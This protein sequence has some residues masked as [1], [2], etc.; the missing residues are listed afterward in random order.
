MSGSA[1]RL[2]AEMKQSPLKAGV[3]LAGAVVAA[4]VWGPRVA[5][6]FGGGPA[7]PVAGPA[8]VEEDGAGEEVEL[9]RLDPGAIRSEF[10]RVSEDAR[11]LA[12][13]VRPIP[14][15]AGAGDPFARPEVPAPPPP[16]L[17]Q[18]QGQE[19]ESNPAVEEAIRAAA[20]R[21]EGVFQFPRGRSVV[22]D[23]V[24]LRVG[25]VLDGFTVTD[26]EGRSALV[27]GAYGEYVVRMFEPKE[28]Q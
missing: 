28:E 18:Q 7:R 26:V 12:L 19:A 1:S 10:I 14:A 17:H 6:A 3:L 8:A 25:D 22:L 2:I 16:L 15:R 9:V 5:A 24:V 20:L 13:L 23:G 27:R 21:L 11:N 4:A